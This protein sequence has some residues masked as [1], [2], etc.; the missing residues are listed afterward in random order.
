MQEENISFEEIGKEDT[1]QSERASALF[2]QPIPGSYASLYAELKAK[3]AP[4]N[5]MSPY[6]PEKVS[7]A[8][9]LYSQLL[10]MTDATDEQLKAM[11]LQAME[12]LGVRFSTE[13]LYKKLTEACN[14]RIFTGASYNKERLEQANRLYQEVLMNAD[15]VFALEEIEKDAKELIDA[16]AEKQKYGDGTRDTQDVIDGRLLVGAVFFSIFLI[17]IATCLILA[18]TH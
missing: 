5:F 17:T 4:E 12:Q 16:F 8:N 13:Q 3:C 18:N 6:D 15:N 1:A 11:R 7:M 9:E 14:P 2:K 10:A